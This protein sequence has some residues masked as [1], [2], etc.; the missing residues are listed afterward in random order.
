MY[1]DTLDKALSFL[2]PFEHKDLIW[3]WKVKLLSIFIASGSS[4]ELVLIHEFCICIDFV[5]Y[6]LIKKWLLLEL[7]IKQF[8]WNHL[9]TLVTTD[10]KKEVI[11]TTVFKEPFEYVSD[12]RFQKMYN[13]GK[14]LS[15]NVGRGVASSA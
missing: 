6:R 14:I 2:L 13:F 12:I 9:N 10:S 4:E 15:T 5:S 8:S 11:I 7:A 1:F 3:S